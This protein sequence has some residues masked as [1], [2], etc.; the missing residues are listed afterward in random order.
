MTT[1]DPQLF[2]ALYRHFETTGP[3]D[4]FKSVFESRIDQATLDAARAV[5]E[6]PDKS[7]SQLSQG[8][9]TQLHVENSGSQVQSIERNRAPGHHQYKPLPQLYTGEEEY[10]FTG[11]LQ[12]NG[13]NAIYDASLQSQQTGASSGLA[14]SLPGAQSQMQRLPVYYVVQPQQGQDIQPQFLQ[15]QPRVPASAFQF[16]HPAQGQIPSQVTQP[17]APSPR[18]QFLQTTQEQIEFQQTYEAEYSRLHK[19][20]YDQDTLGRL[21]VSKRDLF[22]DRGMLFEDLAQLYWNLLEE[23]KEPERNCTDDWVE[24]LSMQLLALLQRME[25]DEIEIQ[26]LEIRYGEMTKELTRIF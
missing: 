9:G 12:V 24:D 5:I 13:G 20:Q 25:E 16:L 19:I 11:D 7:E 23:A 14:Q 10:D 26:Q 15:L 22:H 3:E 17:Q 6:E 18:L 2:E 21:I 1:L 4:E 8:S